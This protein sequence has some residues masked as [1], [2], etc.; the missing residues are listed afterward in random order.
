M[1]TI[2]FQRAGGAVAVLANGTK[3]MIVHPY[4]VRTEGLEQVVARPRAEAADVYWR[5]NGLTVVRFTVRRAYS[6]LTSPHTFQHVHAG[7]VQGRGLFRTSIRSG[8]SA[9]V[10]GRD[11]VLRVLGFGEDGTGLWVHYE[12]KGGV[13]Q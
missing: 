1:R 9:V 8:G 11:F 4:E 5:G 13:L 6:T 10:E 7:Q 2:T 12:A 3:S